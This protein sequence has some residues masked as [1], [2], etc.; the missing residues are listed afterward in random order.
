MKNKKTAILL[1]DLFSNYELSVALSILS[2][3]KK[4]FDF[5]GLKDE[6]IS[7]EYLHAKCTKLLEETIIEEYD[8]LLIPGCMDLEDIISSERILNFLKKFDT[9]DMIIASISSSPILLLKAGMLE[10]RRFMAGVIKEEL[11]EEGFTMEQM[12]NMVDIKELSEN[13]DNI[14]PCIVDDNI[15]TSVGCNFIQFGIQ[16]GKML[17][18]DFQPG[19]YGVNL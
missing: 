6:V 8:S 11:V 14:G 7:E 3:G 12:K 15:L 17:S 16:F 9:K 5:F 18:L 10:N 13:Y 4:Q 2:Q 19:W 1:F